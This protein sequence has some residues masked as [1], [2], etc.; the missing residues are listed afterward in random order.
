MAFDKFW[1]EKQEYDKNRKENTQMVTPMPAESP[2]FNHSILYKTIDDRNNMTDGE[3]RYFIQYNF[4]AIMNNVFDPNVGVTYVNAFRDAR[5]LDAFIDVISGMQFFEP[6]VIVRTDLIVYHY[7]TSDERTKKQE[8]V[9]RMLR[10]GSII[11]R[12]RLIG[13][14]KFNLPDKL[15]NLLIIARYSDFDL[16]VCVKRVDLIMVS[17][18]EL[19]S[20]LD[21]DEY[22]EVTPESVDFLAK[23]LMELYRPEEWTHVLP[24][25]MLDVLPDADENNPKTQWITPEVEAVDSALNL[26]VLKVLDTMLDDSSL[27]RNVLVSYAEGYRIMNKHQPVRFSFNSISFEYPRI[28][29]VLTY[30]AEEEKIYVP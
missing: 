27:L 28:K 19:Y 4:M 14:K 26:A 25:F 30:M 2:M 7:L 24:Y 18:P 22:Y 29:N 9:N 23:I 6:D 5:F 12:Q 15:E 16:R 13:M 21:M 20:K 1:Q 10:I 3:L 11:N 17:S 8:I